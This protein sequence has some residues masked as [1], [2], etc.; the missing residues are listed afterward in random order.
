MSSD[1][2]SL[3]STHSDNDRS[4]KLT[5]AIFELRWAKTEH[6][7]TYLEM[8]SISMGSPLGAEVS[9]LLYSILIRN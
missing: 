1:E 7:K 6:N 4:Q 5:F 2:K 3:H 8:V 9:I